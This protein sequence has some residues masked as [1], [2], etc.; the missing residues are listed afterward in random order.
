[1]GPLHPPGPPAPSPARRGGDEA[2]LLPLSAPERGPG[3]EVFSLLGGEVFAAWISRQTL[4]AVS[5]VRRT[6][7]P[8]GASASSTAAARTAGG[9]SVPPSPSPFTPSGL[10][11]E[12]V[13]RC[14]CRTS[15][16]SVARGIA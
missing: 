14:A 8:S 5:G 7:T 12:G 2:L 13:S 4:P 16:M 1:M 15:G 10:S 9:A 6:S 11:G 3:G